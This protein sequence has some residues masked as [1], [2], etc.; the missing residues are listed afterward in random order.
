[1]LQNLYIVYWSPLLL[2][3][4]IAVNPCTNTYKY[5]LIALAVPI[6][7]V[8]IEVVSRLWV[9]EGRSAKIFST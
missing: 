9:D 7:C 8:N 1:M 4:L 6:S 5:L 3:L 2:R